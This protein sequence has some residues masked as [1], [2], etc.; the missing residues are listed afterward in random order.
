LKSAGGLSGVSAGTGS[1]AASSASSENASR[2]PLPPCTTAPP[3]VL[4]S[5]GQTFHRVAAAVVNI[6]RAAA[7]ARRRTQPSSMLPLPPVPRSL[8]SAL[9]DACTI[10]IRD[11]SAPSSSA[12]I[13]ASDVRTPCP[14]SDLL[15][16]SVTVPSPSIRTHPFGL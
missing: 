12:R 5:L 16:V 10:L 6:A 11:Q 8:N 1:F 4:H 14:I 2:R 9:G 13:I 15:I 7:A 3:S